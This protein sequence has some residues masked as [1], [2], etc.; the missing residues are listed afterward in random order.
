MKRDASAVV[1]LLAL[2]ALP[3]CARHATPA[4]CEA[5]LDRYVELLLREQNPEVASGELV[6]KKE[7]ARE[8]AAHDA[9]FAACPKEV[10]ARELHC[11]MLAGNVDDFEKCLE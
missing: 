6:A 11:A 2:M 7:L 9:A 5:L 4:E 3:A 8:K 10:G 1:A